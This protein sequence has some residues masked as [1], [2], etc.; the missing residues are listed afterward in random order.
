MGARP[1]D[2][3]CRAPSPH[4]V[5]TMPRLIA[6]LLA[7]SLTL[8]L[9]ACGEDGTDPVGPTE[10][11]EEVTGLDY[12]GGA[13]D[14]TI[15]WGGVGRDYTVVVPSTA[16]PGIPSPLILVYPDASRLPQDVRTLAGFD[17]PAEAAGWVVAYLASEAG[18][19]AISPSVSPGSDGVDDTGFTREV[20]RRI[21]DD[22]DID[23]A[24]VHAVGFGEGGVMAQRIACSASDLV[25]SVAS[26]GAGV[27]FEVADSCP[28]AQPVS[29]LQ[30]AGTADPV[31]PWFGGR[32][33]ERY[34]IM[35]QLGG[36]RWWA[37]RLV[38]A[39]AIEI[40]DLPD[41]VDDG[42]SVER[43]RHSACPAGREA[44]LY[45]VFDGGH[46]WPGSDVDLPP[47]H[48]LK[49]LDVQASLLIMDFFT[50]NRR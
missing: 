28:M 44:T 43:N 41:L 22:L 27:S 29:L 3:P 9:W 17:G 4:P 21:V 40:T 6:P 36:A 18:R 12:G 1:T 20:V 26:V 7:L 16:A 31:F 5:L 33:D 37:D 19:W 11:P 49:T 34:G 47:A 39:P 50:R 32:I 45:T 24:R 46:T 23:P 35:T 25:G 48:G 38:C 42:T 8:G 2:D 10:P 15:A 13:F 14:Q 30:F